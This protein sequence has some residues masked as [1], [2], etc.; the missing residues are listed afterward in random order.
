MAYILDENKGSQKEHPIEQNDCEKQFN[1]YKENA[2]NSVHYISWLSGIILACVW[3][4]VFCFVPQHNAVEEPSY[5]YELMRISSTAWV[6][7]FT[8]SLILKLAYWADIMYAKNLTSFLYLYVVTAI[9]CILGHTSTNFI[10]INLLGLFPPVPFV[11]WH[12]STMVLFV[13]YTA[14]WFRLVLLENNRNYRFSFF[15]D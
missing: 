13:M 14:L 6:S 1:A 2:K 7:I 3:V 8:A 15:P 11:V 9:T 10:W 12:V 5:W 4:S